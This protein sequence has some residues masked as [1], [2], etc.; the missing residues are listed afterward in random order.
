MHQY[1][2]PF[3]AGRMTYPGGAEYL[4][5]KTRSSETPYRTCVVSHRVPQRSMRLMPGLFMTAGS[6]GVL[7]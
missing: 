2:E 1:N 6:I 5:L 7:S 3:A 4:R